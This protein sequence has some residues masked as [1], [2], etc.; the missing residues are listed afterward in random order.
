MNL[1]KLKE[2]KNEEIQTRGWLKRCVED[3]TISEYTRQFAINDRNDELLEI[4]NKVQDFLDDNA[5]E[6][7]ETIERYKAGL[8]KIATEADRCGKLMEDNQPSQRDLMGMALDALKEP[9]KTPDLS[10]S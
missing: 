10:K 3:T 7:I 4:K 9:E 6:M 5:K 1:G 2:L 8:E